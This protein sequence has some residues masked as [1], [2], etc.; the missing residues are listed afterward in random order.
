MGSVR[1]DLAA[2][3]R[4][5]WGWKEGQALPPGVR[6]ERGEREGF[7]LH[8][9]DIADERGAAAMGKPVGQ[10]VTL[11]LDGLLR[12]EEDA[13]RRG[14]KALAD[15][16]APL[17][18]DGPVL[19]VGL[20][21]RAVTPDRIGPL[22]VQNLLV[23]RH[24]V[25]GERTLFGHLRPVAALTPGVLGETGME[26]GLLSRAA[27][28]ALRPACV[29]AVDALA[30][31][32]V[33]R[34]CRTV[35]ITDTGI[36]PGSGVGNH[37]QGLTRDTLGLP[38]LALGVPTVVDGETLA[39]DLLGREEGAPPLS[40]ALFV[41]PREVDSRVADFGRVL[42]WGLSLA[43]NPSLSQQELELLLA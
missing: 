27:A 39:R 25:E 22:T 43:L 41:T 7:V 6:S 23:T 15:L 30:A 38:V 36:V 2:E 16:L 9:V 40:R 18:P 5:L 11:E 14:V 24:L 13:F 10:Y 32:S 3:A 34:L 37:R 19:V 26:S 8:R 28:E 42:G 31:R 20:G 29:I 4:P 21:N 1:S 33:E 12:R 17:I 35:Q